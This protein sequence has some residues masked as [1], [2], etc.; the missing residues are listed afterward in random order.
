MFLGVGEVPPGST[1]VLHDVKRLGKPGCDL[2]YT[3]ALLT[4]GLGVQ[5]G[6]KL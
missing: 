5:E 6:S 4:V 2:C 1:W 3:F